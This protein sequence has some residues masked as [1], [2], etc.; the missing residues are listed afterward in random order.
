MRGINYA[1]II[2]YNMIIKNEGDVATDW[3]DEDDTSSNNTCNSGSY[4]ISHS[5]VSKLSETKIG[6]T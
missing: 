3:S 5:I 6:I 4:S 2:M 1:C